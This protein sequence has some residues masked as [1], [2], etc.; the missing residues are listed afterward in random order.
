[1]TAGPLLHLRRDGV[2]VLLDVADTDRLP[3]VVHWGE[4]LG[5]ITPGDA[6]HLHLATT[7]MAGS[8]LP[9]TTDP[10]LL[11]TSTT[12]W[13]GQPGLVGHRDR[14]AWSPRFATTA[15]R[16]ERVGEEAVSVQ[17]DA[18]DHAA[19]L[20]LTSTL[21]LLPGGLLRVRHALRNVGASAYSMERLTVSLPVGADAAE[22]LDM[23]GR[24]ALE[25]VPVRLPF[26]TGIRLRESRRGRPGADAAYVTVAGERGFGFRRGRVWGVHLGWSGNQRS[27]AERLPTG[28]RMLAGGELLLPGEVE[29]APGEEYATPWLYA[30]FGPDGLDSLSARFHRFARSL[31]HLRDRPRP[32]TFNS[33]EAIGFDMSADRLIGLAERAARAGAERFV[34]DD[35]WFGGRRDDRSSLG[36]WRVSP[37]VFPDGLERV[38]TR[39][40][41]LGMEAGIW[42]EP[43]MINE[44]SDL[45]RDHPEWLMRLPDRVPIASRHQQVLDL[46]NPDA[47]SA[48]FTAM[49]EIIERYGIGYVKWDHNRDLIDA[50]VGPDRIAGTHAQTHALYALLGALRAKFPQLTI[51]ACA[52]GGARIDLGILEHSDRFW[53]SDSVDPV[54][55]QAIQRWTALVMPP[56]ILGAHVGAPMAGS[57]RRHHRLNFRAG[58][59]LLGDFGI[60]WDLSHASEGDLAELAEWVGLYRVHRDLLR[61]GS[62]VHGDDPASP[63]TVTG[64]VSPDGSAALYVVASVRSDPQYT[65][66]R[67]VLPGLDPEG[68]YLVTACRPASGDNDYLGRPAWME[69]PG[70]MLPGRLLA[71]IGVEGPTLWPEEVAVLTVIRRD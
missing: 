3:T 48:I 25:R 20:M 71:T 15:I 2:S 45:A 9:P 41:E 59:A 56:E 17:I 70:I 65:T 50:G 23:T 57:T 19:S 44:D 30:S 47:W 39:I 14:S 46:T 42:F 31:P 37:E 51:E 58:T 68:R 32:V 16:E 8:S 6:D 38:T 60:E 43:E 36:D 62:L 52:S 67:V 4:D 66:G 54:D 24:H 12:G 61:Q 18:V 27:F 53:T 63:V 1:M 69:S 64:V 26:E 33:W 13:L 10:S 11:P 28:E 5:R 35:G 55:R 34:I 49:S 22:L 29:L 40:R 7:R 21:E